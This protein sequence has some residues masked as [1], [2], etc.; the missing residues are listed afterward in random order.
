MNIVIEKGSVAPSNPFSITNIHMSF[1]ESDEGHIK[2]SFENDTLEIIV[3]FLQNY[4][5]SDFNKNDLTK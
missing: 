2:L 1:C 3:H 5:C 4:S